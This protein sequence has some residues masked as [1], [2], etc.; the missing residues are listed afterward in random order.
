EKVTNR[1]LFRIA[2]ISKPL[3]AALILK[4]S[5][6]DAFD[7]DD[8][9]CGPGALLGTTYGN[10]PYGQYIE[11]ISVRDLLE[12]KVG[13]WANDGNDPVFQQHHLSQ[14]ELIAHLLNT[15]PGSPCPLCEAPGPTAVHSY[16]GSSVLGRIIE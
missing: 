2:S 16:A 4:L 15:C 14:T 9:V 3:T 12:H 7:L 10:Y 11:D 1:H 5:E 6:A 8:K 13:G